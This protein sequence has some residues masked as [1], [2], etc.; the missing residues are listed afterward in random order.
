MNCRL[1]L[2]I[3]SK[4]YSNLDLSHPEMGNPGVG[5]TQYCFLQLGYY[6]LKCK[7]SQYNVTVLSDEQLML[8]TGINNVV[9]NSIDDMMAKAEELFLDIVI[10]KTPLDLSIYT[11]IAKH[12]KLKVITWSHN[13]FNANVA[14]AISRCSNI[15]L[16]VFVSKQ[17]YDFYIDDDVIK[18]STFIFNMVP[19]VL[20]DCHRTAKP[21][22]LTYMGCLEPVKGIVTLLK[23]WKIIE[24]KYPNAELNIIGGNLYDRTKGNFEGEGKVKSKTEMLIS[25][26][27]FGKNGKPKP[28]I[29]FLG[30]LGEEKYDVFLH[31]SVGIVNPSAKTETFGLGI[32]EMATAKLP[33]VTK[34]WNGHPDVALNGETALLGFSVKQMAAN[35]IRLFEDKELNERMGEM[36]K[37]KMKRFAPSEITKVWCKNLEMVMDGN[38]TNYN[39][40][41]SRPYWNNYKFLRQINSTLRY[42]LSLS[43]LPS[44]VT[45]ETFVNDWLK[46]LRTK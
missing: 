16:N 19:D 1:G 11:S 26:Y 13:Y 43:F 23:I 9:V 39:Y 22:T 15:N 28:N 3:Q 2:Y 34:N 21:F 20:G 29:H 35:V 17:M 24:K 18:K 30:I 42:R 31:S 40:S 36:A 8:P 45:Y 10:L 27:V 7:G 4:G 12:P 37:Q 5:G 41:I 44:M 32:V 6:M 38:F 33:V 14:K 46:K 25:K